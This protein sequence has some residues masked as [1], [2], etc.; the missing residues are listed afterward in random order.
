MVRG[1]LCCSG[2]KTYWMTQI[3]NSWVCLLTNET[4]VQS[5]HNTLWTIITVCQNSWQTVHLGKS[6][7]LSFL[8]TVFYRKEKHTIQMSL[9]WETT[10][11]EW[12]CNVITLICYVRWLLRDSQTG[13]C[14]TQTQ[15]WVFTLVYSPSWL[16]MLS[17]LPVSCSSGLW[18]VPYSLRRRFFPE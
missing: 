15:V 16:K 5:V 6:Q 10:F 4:S 8:P 13:E 11:W 3:F 7:K 1:R 14:T 17:V 2:W 9:M 18:I 12:C